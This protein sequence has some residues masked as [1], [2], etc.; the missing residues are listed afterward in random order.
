MLSKTQ[1]VIIGAGPAGL[2]AA[3]VAGKLGIDTLVLDD[4]PSP[5]GQ[6]YRGIKSTSDNLL[7]VLGPEYVHGRTLLADIEHPSIDLLH[8]T[9]VWQ[10]SEDGTVFFTGPD[11]SSSVQGEQTILATGAL[12]R[13]MPFPGWTLP[14]VMTAGG[15][16]IALKTA[17]LT[18]DGNFVLAG[19]GPLLL[20][21]ARQILDAGGDL[22][23][24]VETTPSH[25]R[26]AAMKYLP[27]M[28]K[29]R[30]M[31][32]DGI[33]LLGVLRK[34]RIPHFRRATSLAAIGDKSLEGLRF[35]SK[36]SIHE[37]PCKLLGIHI[38]VVPNVQ[39][40]R[41]LNL[42]HDWHAD[43]HCWHPRNNEQGKTAYDWLHIAGDGGGIYGALAA[44]LQGT[45]AAWSTAR[46]LDATDEKS[47]HLNIKAA[48]KKL[49]PLLSARRFIDRLYAPSKEFLTPKNE[50]IIC[51]CEEVTAGEIRDYVDLGCLGPNQ[52]KSFGR[53]GM[54]PCQ[55]RYCGLTVS[56]LIADQRGV[57]IADVGYYR[58]RPPIKPITIAELASMDD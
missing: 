34:H 18:P 23:A 9:T 48:Q 4:Q 56:E 20:L 8:D 6:I 27:G 49:A 45:I 38:G 47:A 41:Q 10:I 58:I 54:G 36:G 11:G 12:E 22:S 26:L 28:C 50:T 46:L 37:L 7:K 15:I 29:S 2:A 3:S 31:L 25:N 44:E 19:S 52:T 39:V 5:G 17:G 53:P 14:G 30:K 16:Q 40:T 21:L 43:Q 35:E 42:P 57:A 51:R 13:S 24:V 33:G 32:R 55:G 1:L